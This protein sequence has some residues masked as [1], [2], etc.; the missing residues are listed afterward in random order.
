MGTFRDAK[1]SVVEEFER[2]YLS[3][4]LS[5]TGG[6]VSRAAAIAGMERHHLRALFRKH[7]LRGED[8]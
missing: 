6:N 8:G 2:E 5:R 7:G 1:R 3:R 4:L